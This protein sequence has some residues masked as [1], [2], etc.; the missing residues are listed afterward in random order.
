[1]SSDRRSDRREDT[2][3]P[4]DLTEKIDSADETAAAAVRREQLLAFLADDTPA[5][6]DEDHP[7]LSS[8][9]EAW[10]RKLGTGL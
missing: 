7:E 5:W 2:D 9:A 3:L 1:M 6:K 10:I 4:P 8:G